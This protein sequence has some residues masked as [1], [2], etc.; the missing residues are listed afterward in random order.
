MTTIIEKPDEQSFLSGHANRFFRFG[1]VGLI[2]V[3]VNLGFYT[4]L[5]D[6]V[7]IYDIIAGAIAIELSILNNF[8]L[9]DRWTFRDRSTGGRKQW[10]KRFLAFHLSSGLVA[11]LAQLLMLFVL[12]RFM[13]FW[14]KLAYAIGIGFGALANYLICNLWIFK[15]SNK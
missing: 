5:H 3:L 1:I 13:G 4:L 12:T 8:I 7:G 2:G 14:D 15:A 11:M 10:F 6:V 9:N